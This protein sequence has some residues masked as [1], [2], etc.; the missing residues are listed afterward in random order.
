MLTYS[1]LTFKYIF[2]LA[3]LDGADVIDWIA[4]APIDEKVTVYA[5]GYGDASIGLDNKSYLVAIDDIQADEMLFAVAVAGPYTDAERLDYLGQPS[6]TG[7]VASRKLRQERD[8]KFHAG[9]VPDQY[10][11]EHSVTELDGYWRPNDAGLRGERRRTG[12]QA[13]DVNTSIRIMDLYGHAPIEY[14]HLF[15]VTSI[16]PIPKNASVI[17]ELAPDGYVGPSYDNR[18]FA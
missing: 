6:D 3:Q 7:R 12:N 2:F 13:I 10:W 9:I 4:N 11:R 1:L 15:V 8:A 14:D 16:V 5:A 18:P 17:G